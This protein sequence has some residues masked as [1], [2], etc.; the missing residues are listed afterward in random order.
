MSATL[1][2]LVSG[3]TPADPIVAS[4]W[5]GGLPSTEPAWG[6]SALLHALLSRLLCKTIRVDDDGLAPPVMPIGKARE[7]LSML[8]QLL[9]VCTTRLD[10]GSPI[11]RRRRDEIEL[12]G[13]D[14]EN[15]R[16]RRNEPTLTHR[17][18]LSELQ[19][20]QSTDAQGS[21]NGQPPGEDDAQHV[22]PYGAWCVSAMKLCERYAMPQ[23][24]T[25]KQ[26]LFGI[27]LNQETFDDTVRLHERILVVLLV[28]VIGSP[29]LAVEPSEE[30]TEVAHS[31]LEHVLDMLRAAEGSSFEARM[32]EQL[33]RPTGLAELHTELLPLVPDAYLPLGVMHP[34]KAAGP[35]VKKKQRKGPKLEATFRSPVTPAAVLLTSRAHHERIVASMHRMIVA[36][37]DEATRQ[38]AGARSTRKNEGPEAE[39]TSLDHHQIRHEMETSDDW[40]GTK[41]L[42]LP[43]KKVFSPSRIAQSVLAA[44]A[45]EMEFKATR[46]ICPSPFDDRRDRTRTRRQP[47]SPFES[48]FH[49]DLNGPIRL[50]SPTM[51]AGC[52]MDIE[53]PKSVLAV[54]MEAESAKAYGAR[55]HQLLQSAAA[56]GRSTGDPQPN[57]SDRFIVVV[58]A[59]QDEDPKSALTKSNLR[60]LLLPSRHHPEGGA[61]S[62]SSNSVT[63]TAQDEHELSAPNPEHIIGEWFEQAAVHMPAAHNVRT[64]QR[65]PEAEN[66]ALF[67]G[68]FLHSTV[69]SAG[70]LMNRLLRKYAATGL[71]EGH[72]GTLVDDGDYGGHPDLATPPVHP[73]L[74]TPPSDSNIW[75]SAVLG[76][77]RTRATLSRPPLP[78]RPGVKPAL[79]LPAVDLKHHVVASSA[80]HLVRTNP[81]LQKKFGQREGYRPD[82]QNTT[83]GDEGSDAR[84]RAVGR[85]LQ[86]VCARQA[87]RPPAASG[88]RSA[89]SL[90]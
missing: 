56:Q 22:V 62:P 28:E 14:E 12:E 11:R 73:G 5:R 80:A 52:P 8:A 77:D 68:Q 44:R 86:Q 60:R 17:F 53:R 3:G 26:I 33:S 83:V 51:L 16:H 39:A 43:E 89:S 59:T 1:L 7:S 6:R 78:P 13:L 47:L 54:D 84:E 67:P 38:G 50:A 37:N 76:I 71:S 15:L 34:V 87:R 18:S 36:S 88:F 63:S 64:E 24:R 20:R 41:E 69:V 90:R 61:L 82:R 85:L 81:I 29:L 75:S 4:S 45:A 21:R 25:S 65:Q 79:P 46:R 48:R 72:F 70:T 35:V 2:Q 31:I 23:E 49:P 19:P 32:L 9:D 10:R 27:D 57:G 58:S 55:Y 42:A 74:A 30:Q 66:K 40:N